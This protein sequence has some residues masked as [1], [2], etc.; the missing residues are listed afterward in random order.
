MRDSDLF[1]CATACL[2]LSS[3]AF[4]VCDSVL[5]RDAFRSHSVRDCASF[6]YATAP[7]VSTPWRVLHRAHQR[8]PLMGDSALFLRARAA[9][10]SFSAYGASFSCATAPSSIVRDGAFLYRV[11][12]RLPLSCA[13]A[14]SFIVR[15]GTFIYRARRRLHLSCATAPPSFSARRRL[16][17]VRDGA[18][19]LSRATAPS[20]I[21]RNGASPLIRCATAPSSIARDAPPP[22]Q[23]ATAP[24]SC[25]RRRPPLSC[26]T[27]PSSIVR[28][29]AFL[30]RA[31]W[32]PPLIQCATAPHSMRDSA[33]FSRTTARLLHLPSRASL[34]SLLR[35]TGEKINFLLRPLWGPTLLR[36]RYSIPH[37]RHVVM[38]L[39]APATFLV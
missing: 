14:P 20:S 33:P 7:L 19:P 12:R 28:N 22:I 34:P 10:D 31:R 5:R 26:A 1:P 27:A 37:P 30:Y 9:L 8:P 32:R 35:A 3:A 6:S 38:H 2:A 13:T 29:G 23:C 21:V 18:P 15:D 39:A 4:F 17:L 25:A 11:R 24:D 16:I 36:M